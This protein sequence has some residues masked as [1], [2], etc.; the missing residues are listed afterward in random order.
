MKVQMAFRKTTKNTYVFDEVKA[1]DSA[2]SVVPTLYIRKEAFNECP[3][4]IEITI[5]VIS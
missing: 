2:P 4:K 1:V 3:L 5:E